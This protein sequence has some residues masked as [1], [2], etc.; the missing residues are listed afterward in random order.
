MQLTR[1]QILAYDIATTQL[2]DDLDLYED[3]IYETSLSPDL[4]KNMLQT[5]IQVSFMTG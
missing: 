4:K 2:R 3:D 5:K 1:D